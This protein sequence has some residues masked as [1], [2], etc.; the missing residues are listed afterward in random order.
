MSQWEK[1]FLKYFDKIVVNGC[2]D[3]EAKNDFPKEFPKYKNDIVMGKFVATAVSGSIGITGSLFFSATIMAFVGIVERSQK[4]SVIIPYDTII[5]VKKGITEPPPKKGAPKGPEGKYRKINPTDENDKHADSLL[6]YTNDSTL[7]Q[8]Y[9]V[10]YYKPAFSLTH[11]F[12]HHKPIPQPQGQT[13][14]V[15][16]PGQAPPPGQVV[17]VTSP[18][19]LPSGQ[20]IMMASNGQPIM[21]P[22]G[23]FT[24]PN[25]PIA[26]NGQPMMPNVPGMMMTNG[27][28]QNGNLQPGQFYSS[29]YSSQQPLLQ[30]VLT[31]PPSFYTSDANQPPPGYGNP[32]SGP[33]PGDNSSL[34]SFAPLTMPGNNTI[35]AGATLTLTDDTV[36]KGGFGK[37]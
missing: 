16:Q 14:I 3:W 34:T 26:A 37:Q 24:N 32:F 33:Q 22:P 8:F 11:Y 17:Y 31:P 4:I 2:F 10:P 28:L 30:P 13:I 1:N 5:D 18:N 36:M 6:V 19:G 27:P 21:F 15:L 35:S 25:V 29:Q 12:Y 9:N 23:Q 20:S 7:H